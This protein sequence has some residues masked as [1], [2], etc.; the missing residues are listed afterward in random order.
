MNLR[1]RLEEL[2][3][4]FGEQLI[5]TILT[6][7]ISELDDGRPTPRLPTARKRAAK[8]LPPKRAA[9]ALPPQRNINMLP[10]PSKLR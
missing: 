2:A 4:N 8:A 1:D 3:V 5:A 9:K 6:C 7:P 10:P